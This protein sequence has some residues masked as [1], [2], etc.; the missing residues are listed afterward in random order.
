MGWVFWADYLLEDPVWGGVQTA[1]L[2][3]GDGLPLAMA[4]PV[5]LCASS[6]LSA[7]VGQLGPRG[8]KS[9]VLFTWSL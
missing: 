3:L 6:L 8:P 4:Q 2:F 7:A 5:I 9:P 1:S